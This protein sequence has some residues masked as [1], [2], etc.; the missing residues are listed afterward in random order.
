MGKLLGAHQLPGRLANLGLVRYQLGQGL[1]HGHRRRCHTAAHIG[2]ARQ[3]QQALDRTVLAVFSME[4]GEHHIDPLPHHAVP[5]K[6]QQA[7]IPDGRDGRPAV[8]GPGLPLAGGQQA[9]VSAGIENPIPFLGNAHGIDIIF[10][11]VN[12]VQN[13][14]RRTQGNLMLRGY[15]AKQD[16]DTQFTHKNASFLLGNPQNT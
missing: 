2:D 5:L 6:G 16:T 7:L 8:G 11:L 4:H 9:V 15:A 1:V 14:L 12:V 10:G 3:L 13:R